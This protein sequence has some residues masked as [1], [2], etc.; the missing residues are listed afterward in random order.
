MPVDNRGDEPSL[1][2]EP[3]DIFE[4]VPGAPES[5]PTGP[6]ASSDAPPVLGATSDGSISDEASEQPEVR[7]VKPF[8]DEMRQPFNG[9]AFIGKLTSDFV[10]MGHKIVIRTLTDDEVLEVGLLVKPYMGTYGEAKAYQTA[11][12]AAC[13]VSVDGQPLP[14]P[15]S[16]VTAAEWLQTRF[17]WCKGQWHPIVFD[18]IYQEF[19]LLDDD[20]ERVLEA[21]GEALGR[22]DQ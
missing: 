4:S 9:L 14:M 17:D 21:M 12:V 8:P 10:W 16:N 3:E 22:T 19:L 15:L 13:V 5:T 7:P 18:A 20:V 2:P 1:D 11:C 6:E